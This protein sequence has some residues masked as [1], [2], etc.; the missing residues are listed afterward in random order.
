MIKC[1]FAMDEYCNVECGSNDPGW[2]VSWGQSRLWCKMFSVWIGN[3]CD[4][5]WHF[6]KFSAQEEL[7][8]GRPQNFVTPS[9]WFDWP[10]RGRGSLTSCW[11][12]VRHYFEE[13]GVAV[14]ADRKIA[15]T[16]LL[17]QMME[18]WLLMMI[19]RF[20]THQRTLKKTLTKLPPAVASVYTGKWRM[21]HVT[22]D[23]VERKF[24]V[25]LLF[26]DLQQMAR[27]EI[28]TKW[29]AKTKVLIYEWWSL[30]WWTVD[31]VKTHLRNKRLKTMQMLFTAWHSKNPPRLFQGRR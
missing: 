13:E 25:H 18:K 20:R 29:Y 24:R 16:D 6:E 23:L 7:R 22:V 31:K 1:M 27:V 2:F 26:Y 4:N 19:W 11:M 3:A 12:E 15:R 14:W 21:D 8:V 10:K 17:R 5:G 9:Y 30:M 28:Y